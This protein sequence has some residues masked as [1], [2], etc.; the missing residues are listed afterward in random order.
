MVRGVDHDD[1]NFGY[2]LRLDNELET[3]IYVHRYRFLKG[4]EISIN[5]DQ[6]FSFNNIAYCLFRFPSQK[7]FHVTSSRIE[8]FSNFFLEF[9]RRFENF[10][11]KIFYYH[12]I[13]YE[14]E[15]YY[16]LTPFNWNKKYL[17]S[18]YQYSINQNVFWHLCQ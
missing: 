3:V 2:Q 6:D 9:L 15:L 8:S 17:R 14:Y 12:S 11:Y 13:P 18:I 10:I 4:S 16:F 1:V 7:N 5:I